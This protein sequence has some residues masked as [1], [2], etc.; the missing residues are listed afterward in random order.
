MRRLWCKGYCLRKWARRSELKS[1]TRLFAFNIA[2]I[3]LRKLRIQL[4]YLQQWVNGKADWALDSW[5]SNRAKRKKTLNA[6]PVVVCLKIYLVSRP[7]AR[8]G[9]LS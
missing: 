3:P 9:G 6:K 4:F 1:W 2:L 7:A 5:Y 8:G